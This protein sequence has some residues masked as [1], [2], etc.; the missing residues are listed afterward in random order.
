VGEEAAEPDH[1]MLSL[2]DLC[3]RRREPIPS[4]CLFN[5]NTHTV[6]FWMVENMI[7]SFPRRIF[8]RVSAYRYRISL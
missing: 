1:L 6:G 4:S 3:G 2:Q 5:L 7:R 8:A